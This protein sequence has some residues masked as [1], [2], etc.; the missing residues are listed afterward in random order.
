MFHGTAQRIFLLALAVLYLTACS[1]DEDLSSDESY[2]TLQSTLTPVAPSVLT[3]SPP[4]STPT[5]EPIST[6][7]QTP[8]PTP[9]PPMPTPTFSP[10][11]IILPTVVPYRTATTIPSPEE[12]LSRK[13]HAI[14]LKTSILRDL[15]ARGTVE[16]IFLTKKE[17]RERLSEDL[18]DNQDQILLEQKLYMILGILEPKDDLFDLLVGIFSD[19]VLGF[20]DTEANEMFFVGDKADFGEQGELTV[21]HEF[22][23]GLQQFHFGI[24]NIRASIEDNFSQ[25][26]RMICANDQSRALEALVEGDAALVQL[27][28]MMEHFD[29][30]QQTAAQQA[31]NGTDIS[32]FRSAPYVIQRLIAFPYSEGPPF[33]MSLFLKTNDY[34]LVNEAYSYVPRSTEQIIHPEKYKSREAPIEVEEPDLLGSLGNGWSE[35]HRNTFGEMFLRSYL[36]SEIAPEEAAV[37]AAGWGGDIFTLYEG[38]DGALALSAMTT[39]DTERDAVEFF[40]GFRALLQSGTESEWEALEDA[41]SAFILRSDIQTTV[42]SLRGLDVAIFLAPTSLFPEVLDTL[43]SADSPF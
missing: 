38:P 39:W 35:I 40:D 9:E 2:G 36:E 33:V 41:A 32:I 22:V 16:H 15:S 34:E 23:H 28:Y 20:F 5:L 37:A 26:C 13:M 17:L 3:T 19:I 4:T 24:S 12:L 21:A 25:V 42:I 30:Q 7:M 18:E 31:N 29:E 10:G 43:Q 1:D 14:G 27:I 6:V 11:A 8:L